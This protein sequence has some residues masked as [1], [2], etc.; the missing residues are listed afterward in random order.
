[1]AI[2]KNLVYT[3]FHRE[4]N[5]YEVIY[6]GRVAAYEVT[7]KDL[8][9]SGRVERSIFNKLLNEVKN[10]DGATYERGKKV[11]SEKKTNK[12]VESKIYGE[13]LGSAVKKINQKVKKDVYRMS[14]SEWAWNY[15]PTV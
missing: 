9:Y 11:N 10:K 5:F 2:R 14:R 15:L 7:G 3:S 1:M 8:L 4:A 13:E 12:K 6:N